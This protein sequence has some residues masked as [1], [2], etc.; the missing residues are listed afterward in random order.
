MI[1]KSATAIEEAPATDQFVDSWDDD[2]AHKEIEIDDGR[3]AV[4]PGRPK[5][6][7]EGASDDL[8]TIKLY[9]K[10][11]RK[12]SLLTFAEEQALAKRVQEGDAEARAKMIESNLRLVVSIGKRY[13]N[14]GL[15]FSDIIEEGN[16]G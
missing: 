8:D 4:K 16:L 2:D 14:R 12:S 6:G 9:L 5:R 10:E 3:E 11:I 15:P 1:G 13:I 7:S